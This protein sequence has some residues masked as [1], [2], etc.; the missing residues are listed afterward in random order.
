[1]FYCG[2]HP[3]LLE[4]LGWEIVERLNRQ[5]HAQEI[6]V[7]KAADSILQSIFGHYDDMIRVLREEETLNKLL[8]ILF[9]PIIDVKP[10]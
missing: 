6:D 8:Q 10:T 3:Y 7:E 2:A 5:N 9:G 1:M 4:M